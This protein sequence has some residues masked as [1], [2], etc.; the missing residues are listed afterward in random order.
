[1]L[2]ISMRKI[3]IIEGMIT[4]FITIP[5]IPDIGVMLFIISHIRIER[6]H[7]QITRFL[8]VRA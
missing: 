1:M 8:P 7:R 5:Y 2:N 4:P 3:M 6:S